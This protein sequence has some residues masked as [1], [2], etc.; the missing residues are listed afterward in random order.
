MGGCCSGIIT[1]DNWEPTYECV[2]TALPQ[3]KPTFYLLPRLCSPRALAGE[4]IKSLDNETVLD[5]TAD[6]YTFPSHHSYGL[7]FLFS[8]LRVYFAFS[9]V[10]G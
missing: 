3:P 10:R 2:S 6:V 7:I 4:R 8:W 5:V 1:G 9:E